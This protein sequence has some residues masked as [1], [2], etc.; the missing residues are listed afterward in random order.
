VR[1]LK[2]TQV[3]F[4][5]ADEDA[6]FIS[7]VLS[8]TML[9]DALAGAATE[10]HAPEAMGSHADEI[11]ACVTLHDA[12]R[13]RFAHK[14]EHDCRPSSDLRKN[15]TPEGGRG[16]HNAWSEARQLEQ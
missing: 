6:D 12:L 4:G 13:R 1:T 16:T 11:L 8:Q 7:R 9:V 5:R 14:T 10:L 2:S 15:F 3:G